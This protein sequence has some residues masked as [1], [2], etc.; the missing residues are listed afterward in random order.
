MSDEQV[1]TFHNSKSDDEQ[2]QIVEDFSMNSAPSG[3]WS[4]P[5]SH[6]RASTSTSSA[7]T[8]STSISRGRSSPSSSATAASTATART[9]SPEIRYLIYDPADAEVAS[10]VRVV[11]KLIEKENVA[12][13]ALGDAGSVMGLY[14]ETAEEQ[15]I[16]AALRKRTEVDR[17]KALEE[18]APT[19]DGFDPWAFA[20]LD[21]AGLEAP[22]AT[23]VETSSLPSLFADVDDYLTAGLRLVYG[24]LSETRLGSR[25]S[26]RQLRATRRPPP[27]PRRPP[28]VIPRP[29]KPRY[30]PPPHQ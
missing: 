11:A 14:S 2:Q 30:P 21:S 12:H 8:S 6:R 3:C 17:T 13:K 9:H 27:A 18:A 7:T 15:A 16:V 24:D 19:T 22:P 28:A 25:R 29:T 4:P 10:D 23:Q 5:T 26:R 1:Q 20:G